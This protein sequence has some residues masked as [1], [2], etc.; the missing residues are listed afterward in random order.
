MKQLFTPE[1]EWDHLTKRKLFCG[2][3]HTS[4]Y[5]DFRN[6]F[7]SDNMEKEDLLGGILEVKKLSNKSIAGNVTNN[8]FK[9]TMRVPN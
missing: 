4:V 6:K 2:H 9:A 1:I 8:A 7:C 5:K 3:D